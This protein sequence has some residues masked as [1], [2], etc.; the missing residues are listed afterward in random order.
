MAAL[1]LCGGS[2]VGVLAVGRRPLCLRELANLQI[3]CKG[4]TNREGLPLPRL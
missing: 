4:R 2:A 3:S 1:F